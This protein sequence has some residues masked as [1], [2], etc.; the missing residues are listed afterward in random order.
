LMWRKSP[1][2][3]QT[4]VSSCGEK[5]EILHSPGG[6]KIPVISTFSPSFPQSTAPTITIT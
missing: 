3:P 5:V 4:P 1:I 2:F 6:Q